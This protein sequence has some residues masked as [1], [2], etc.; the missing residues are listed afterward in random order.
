MRSRTPASAPRDE[1]APL[2]ATW[3]STWASTWEA[4]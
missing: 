1:T 4:K 2:N 3:A